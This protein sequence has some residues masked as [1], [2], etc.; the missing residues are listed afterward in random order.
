MNYFDLYSSY[1]DRTIASAWDSRV[2][3]RV[4]IPFMVREPHHERDSFVVNA[5]PVATPINS[6]QALSTSKGSDRIATQS[7]KEADNAPWLVAR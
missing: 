2:R 5:N 1:P 6:V 7:L 3:A 4:A